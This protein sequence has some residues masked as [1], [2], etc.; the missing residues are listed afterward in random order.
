MKPLLLLSLAAVFSC[1]ACFAEESCPW[2]GSA[3]AAGILGDSVTVSVT[4]PGK[5]KNNVVCEFRTAAVPS[6]VLK[7]EVQTMAN[8]AVNFA[9]WLAKCKSER[10]PVRGIGNEAVACPVDKGSNI[11]EQIIS[12]VR[13]RA[14][15]VRITAKKT[16]GPPP[17]LRE[18]VNTAAQLAAGNLF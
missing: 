13:D 11:A 4:H 14:L 1:S 10:Q 12:R 6:S 18:Q 2:L 3:T 17:P 7:I 16:A 8:P 9:S 15:L 5:D